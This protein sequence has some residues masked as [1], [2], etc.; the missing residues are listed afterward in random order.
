VNV[1]K[2]LLQKK[3]EKRYKP[4][5]RSKNK[6][7]LAGSSKTNGCNAAVIIYQAGATIFLV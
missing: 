4:A 5:T 6:N 7:A 1:A 2:K 3:I